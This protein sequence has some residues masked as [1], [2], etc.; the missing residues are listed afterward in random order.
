VL[1]VLGSVGAA[2]GAADDGATSTL[3]DSAAAARSTPAVR[4]G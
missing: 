2:T 4:T 3:V 1:S